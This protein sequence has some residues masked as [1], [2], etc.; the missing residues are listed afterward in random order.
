MEVLQ[1]IDLFGV[2]LTFRIFDNEK[3]HS[4]IS[5]SLTLITLVSTLLF[6]YFFGLDFIFHL[7]SQ[8]LQS[9]RTNKEYEFYNLSLNDF[10]FA[11]RIE[12]MY[13]QEIN[14]TDILYPVI[15]YYSYKKEEIEIIKYDKCK[16]YNISFSIPNDIKNY[17]CIDMK[18]YSQGGGWENDNKIEYIFINIYMY[19]K[20]KSDFFNLLNEY[21]RMYLIIYYPT[22]YFVPDEEI[23]Y[24]IYYNKKYIS[25]DPKLANINRYYIRKYIFED[26]EGWVIPKI[27]T[28]KAFG[29]SDIG[30]SNYLNDIN[31][32]DNEE[33]LVY[34]HLY[35]GNFYIDRKHSYYKRSFTKVF[36]SLAINYAFFITIYIIC[37]LIA[38]F[39]NR[40]LLLETIMM[41]G[42]YLNSMKNNT[43]NNFSIHYIINDFSDAMESSSIKLKILNNN[44][45]F[46][47]N[48]NKENNNN[49]NIR[50]VNNKNENKKNSIK[51]EN[52]SIN[53]KNQIK[54]INHNNKKSI[55]KFLLFYIF[56]F[57]LPK[58]EKVQ[59]EIELMNRKTLLKKLDIHNYLEHLK[60]IDML[61]IQFQKGKIRNKNTVADFIN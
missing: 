34:Y 21:G 10:F 53:K 52:S 38:S 20:N 8:V 46:I 50:N 41:N 14:I 17:Y 33:F 54:L 60:K 3:Y 35:T 44:K 61:Y 39:C 5:L 26:D 2:P 25:L 32:D 56:N 27:K 37:N 31:E 29:I 57:I 13:S 40:F 42:N 19:G 48:I 47:N 9:T 12:D 23:P 51:K 4:L 22:V 1:K 43:I 55:Y 24:K 18:D 7:E 36:Q 59:Y 15:G 58:K 30:T 11:W 45:I 6:I 16:N 28:Y 49:M